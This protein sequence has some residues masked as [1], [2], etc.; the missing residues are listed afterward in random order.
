MIAGGYLIG[1][2]GGGDDSEDSASTPAGSSVATGGSLEMNFP[3]T[4][5]Q[6]PDPPAIPGLELRNPIALAPRDGPKGAGLGAGMTD[7]TG[8][9]LLPASFLSTLEEAPPRDDAVKLGD[10]EAYRY[11]DLEPEGYDKSL[12]L[13]VAPTTDGVATVACTAGTGARRVPARVRGRGDRPHAGERR[14][15]CAGRRRGLPRTG[16]TQRWP[17]LNTSRKKGVGRAQEGRNA[18]EAEPGRHEPGARP[19]RTPRASCRASR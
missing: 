5:R 8:P 13:Y 12:T 19:T 3:G 9:E 4:W 18:E 2:S 15:L 10:I 16:S 6:T 7:A 17:A 14:D 1:S 11:Q